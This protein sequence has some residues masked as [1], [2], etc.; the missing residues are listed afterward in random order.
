MKYPQKETS[1][2]GVREVS[3][4]EVVVIGPQNW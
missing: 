4:V 1:C 2:N 3:E